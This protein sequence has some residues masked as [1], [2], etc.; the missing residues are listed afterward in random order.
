M[1]TLK[2]TIRRAFLAFAITLGVMVGSTQS[3]KAD[4]FYYDNY[5][6]NY[7]YYL[8]YYNGSGNSFYYYRAY[9]WYYYWYGCYYGDYYGYN[10]D[11]PGYKSPNYRGGTPYW[12]YYYDYYSY[13]GDYYYRL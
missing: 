7:Q 2:K 9:A 6:H 1:N 5:W 13:Y 11:S 4:T 8:G 12:C 10:S 3:C